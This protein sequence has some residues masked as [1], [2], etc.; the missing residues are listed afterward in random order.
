M[1]N[2][3][4]YDAY[5]G[6]V[7]NKLQKM[8][9]K[10]VIPGQR[11]AEAVAS[12][13]IPGIVQAQKN[14]FFS[15]Q[16]NVDI[17]SEIYAHFSG[18]ETADVAAAAGRGVEDITILTAI[19]SIAGFVAVDRAMADPETAITYNQI[20]SVN[21][22]SPYAA[23]DKVYDQFSCL[24]KDT[25]LRMKRATHEL[26]AGAAGVASFGGPIIPGTIVIT[27]K[28]DGDD[29]KGTLEGRDLDKDG[30]IHF[31]YVSATEP[32]GTA[33]VTVPTAVA[34]DYHAGTVGYTTEDDTVNEVS[35]TV[36]SMAGTG[37]NILRVKGKVFE[38]ATLVAE[39][40]NLV[41]EGNLQADA[42]RNKAMQAQLEAGLTMDYAQMSFRQVLEIYIEYI[43]LKMVKA[44]HDAAMVSIANQ[45]SG[46]YIDGDISGFALATSEP[47]AIGYEVNRVIE[48]LHAQ[49]LQNCK[50]GGT[51]IVTGI[52]GARILASI[53]K[54]YGTF[55]KAPE[56]NT[57]SEGLCGTYNGIPVIR[58]S[59][60][61]EIQTAKY[62]NYYVM[63]KDASGK[64]GPVALGTYLPVYTTEKA[65][66][67]D[68]PMQFAQGLFS[69]LAV[70]YIVPE[71]VAVGRIKYAA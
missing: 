39:S 16:G 21:T 15:S 7:G 65:L 24:D 5:V 33:L 4:N 59:W 1:V 64:V 19:K 66:N 61:D 67:F 34:V 31:R 23:G 55:E 2:K 13:L 52:Q 56:F 29:T 25:D 28:G 51:T 70:Q 12:H 35:G 42:Y 3:K 17:V 58:H 47:G 45:P 20:V 10:L 69:Y 14:F 30:K 43:N 26:T 36:D 44:L 8:M 40:E 46:T 49:L 9:S 57:E 71:L 50:K 48:S 68:N 32:E 18:V 38:S 62:A 11:N 54:I 60:V 27:I 53:D 41:L 6:R 37:S 22:V 63:Y